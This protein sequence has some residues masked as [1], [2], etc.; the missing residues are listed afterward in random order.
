MDAAT[1][2][3]L[4]EEKLQ[5]FLED[6]RFPD[7]YTTDTIFSLV[8]DQKI[9][10]MTLVEYLDDANTL[11]FDTDVIG[12]EVYS[13][14]DGG[15][16]WK[17]THTQYLDLVYNTYGYYFGQIRVSPFDSKKLYILGV[18]ILISGDGGATWKS[19][20]GDNVHG[21][22]HALWLSPVR[23]KHMI[24]GNDG[25]INISY[26]DGLNYFKCN[27]P[28]VGQF[29]SV[30]T[31]RAEPYHVYGGLQDNGVWGGSHLYSYSTDWH[32]SG[33]YPYDFLYGGDGM[34]VQ[35]DFRNNNTVYTGLQFGNYARVDKNSDRS[36]YITPRHDLMERPFRWNWQAP[37]LLS[38]HQQDIFYMGSNYLHRSLDGGES[39]DVISPDLTKGGKPGD[40]PYGTLTTI[41]ES[42]LEIGVIYTGSDDGLIY[43]TQDFG[44]T[45]KRLSDA[46]PPDLWVSRVKASSH[47]K[48]RVYAS[49]NGYRWDNFNSY[50]YASE[51][52]GATWTRIGLDLPA[53]PINVVIEDPVNE[54][55]LFVGTDH[56]LYVSLDRGKHFMGTG[57]TLPSVAVHDLDIQ[58]VEHHLL[59]GTHGRSFYLADLTQLELM[60][61]S[62]LADDLHLFA[63]PES[64]MRSSERWGTRSADWIEYYDP[65]VEIPVYSITAR[66][67]MLQVLH[68]DVLVYER[69]VQVDRGLNFIEYD[70]S[71]DKDKVNKFYKSYAV[72]EPRATLKPSENG[73][74]YL[75]KGAYKVIIASSGI[76]SSQPF[77]LK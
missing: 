62:L 70:L 63:I 23:D 73:V 25:G 3:E 47:E 24:L 44:K 1:F 21:D 8:R 56:G 38:R 39:F 48:S 49:L 75:Q 65:E 31:D 36:K 37:I 52:F 27:S 67:I 22:H 66:R 28:A 13:S 54:D 55:I 18:P 12:A 2:L 77:E 76:E 59:V 19:I 71:V 42:P 15:R 68:G 29:Y 34:Q 40:V 74:Q 6:N 11:L 53:E 64:G 72:V 16:S 14:T 20:D 69:E 46:L 26:D 57:N 9:S 30:H 33:D 41:H 60:D 35:V 50:L 10:P 43:L 17:K 58:P 5:A 45:W 32:N 51:D 4:P 7:K 61:S